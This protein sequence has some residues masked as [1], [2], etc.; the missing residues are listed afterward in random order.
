MSKKIARLEDDNNDLKKQMVVYNEEVK[1]KW[2]KY[3]EKMKQDLNEI[4]IELKDLASNNK[5]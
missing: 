2:E 5:K 1:L 4:D 3:R